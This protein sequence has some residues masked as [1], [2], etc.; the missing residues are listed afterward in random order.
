VGTREEEGVGVKDGVISGEHINDKSISDNT[1]LFGTKS[2][3]TLI[4]EEKRMFV[5]MLTK[6]V[7][8]E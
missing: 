6:K 7:V 4:E 8:K 5:D 3:A 1:G 2:E